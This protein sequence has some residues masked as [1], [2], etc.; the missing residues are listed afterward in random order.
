M[1]VI[2]RS[3]MKWNSNT[4]D[5]VKR[6]SN[7][8]WLIRRLKGIDAQPE[9]LVDMF[10]KQCRSILEFA[11]PAWHGAITMTERQDI[12]RVHKGAPH[13][14][15]ADKYDSYRNALKVT[16]LETLETRRDRLCLKNSK[17][18]N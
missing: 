4:D 3:D 15:L 6:A 1:G 7:K 10:I 13:I 14:I 12:E 5:I 16:N 8:L 17:H 9:E 18:K 2:V 11:A